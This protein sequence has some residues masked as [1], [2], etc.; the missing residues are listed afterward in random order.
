MADLS[1]RLPTEIDSQKRFVDAAPATPSI[2]ESLARFGSGVAAV[3][4]R[5]W[6][7]LDHSAA[8]RKAGQTEAAKNDA[9]KRVVVFESQPGVGP[10][11]PP[12]SEG[13]AA[14][15][16]PLAQKAAAS[17][18]AAAQGHIDPAMAQAKGLAALRQAMAA[19]PGHEYAVYQVFKDAGVEN[20]IMQQY[21]NAETAVESDESAQRDTEHKIED[22][23]VNKYG[24]VNYFHMG[25]EEQAKVR[26]TVGDLEAKEQLLDAQS[27]AA[28]LAVSQANLT[29]SQRTEV[30]KS[31]SKNVLSASVSYMNANF[32]N[33]MKLAI[34]QLGDPALT[35]NPTRL[36]QLQDHL[37][38]VTLPTM[39]TLY[40]NTVAQK[41]GSLTPD[42]RSELDKQYQ[43]QRTALVNL[44]S[45][46]QSVVEMNKRTLEN[47]S[48][49]AGIDYAK[50][51]PTLMRVQKMIGPQAVGVLLSPSVTGNP[52]LMKA[53]S[54][55]LSGAINDPSKVPSFTEFVQS[56]NG[57]IDPNA[58]D[59]EKLR[60]AAPMAL[61]AT[62]ALAKDPVSAN[63]T[64]KE[65]HQALV[66]SI[67]QTAAQAVDVVPQW[68]FN[69]ILAQG[70]A[71]NSKGVTTA[72]FFTGTINQTDKIDAVNA[73]VPAV[74]RTYKTLSEM[75][76]GDRYFDVKLDPHTL[77][78]KTVW[79][80]QMVPGGS[81]ADH[82]AFGLVSAASPGTYS[83]P[84]VK[85][86]PSTKTLEQTATLNTMLNNLSRAGE[87]GW[88]S[89]LG[90][91]IS[92]QEAR[93]YFATGAI[94][95]KLKSTPT[96][97]KSGK[98]PEQEVDDA[99]SHMLDFVNNLDSPKTATAGKIGPSPL[100]GAIAT[101]A[102]N[103]GVP[104][105]IAAALFHRES[106]GGKNLVSDKGAV[107]PGQIMPGTAAA[108]G[109]ADVH[110]LKP[111][112]NVDLAMRILADN[113]KKTGS[114][115]DALAMYHSGHDLKTAIAHNMTDGHMKTSDYVASTM[116]TAS[117]I[118]PEN[119]ARYG[120][121]RY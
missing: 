85:P 63:G 110:S 14:N 40:S 103:H 53:L 54:N 48:N 21:K 36:G 5:A 59:P 41:L 102:E 111:E 81:T 79:N 27:K 32:S 107:G 15:A 118:S 11:I 114:W 33:V 8:V 67:K 50:A 18:T 26:A 44:I 58:W 62:N 121:V 9:A 38:S 90:K 88:D 47:I 86:S 13:A 42:D 92:Y 4:D 93:K 39:D 106:S 91:G 108:Y 94:P 52:A 69:N 34:N 80:G 60:A 51:A 57:S 16:A 70:K 43:M 30:E 72:L 2:F 82:A 100:A 61:A 101:S 37:M 113:F 89:T 3:A 10:Q 6:D 20:M 64:D 68:G 71:L 104:T 96:K 1:A 115:A 117:A 95:E 28:S 77:Q 76:S 74:T 23:A 17:Q 29:A 24:Y 45:G 78:W 19:N 97:S 66:N 25:P 73:W 109:V 56:L 31:Q 65:A 35:G 112:E 7:S 55:E 22:A 46:P 120:Y 83:Q 49:T 119:L 84:Q 87:G 98:T 99:V 12:G 116:A 75:P 105:N